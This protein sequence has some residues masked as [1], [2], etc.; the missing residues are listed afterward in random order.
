M[1]EICFYNLDMFFFIQALLYSFSIIFCYQIFNKEKDPSFLFSIFAMVVL[2]INIFYAG[3]GRLAD[4][5][6]DFSVRL[7]FFI[8]ILIDAFFIAFKGK[9]KYF[10]RSVVLVLLAGSD[11]TYDWLYREIFAALMCFPLFLIYFNDLKK[12]KSSGEI[13]NLSK[14]F[15]F[16]AL[17]LIFSFIVIYKI[18]QKDFKRFY[19]DTQKNLF[20]IK[21]RIEREIDNSHTLLRLFPGKKI[22]D[23]LKDPIENNDDKYHIYERFDKLIS[24]NQG[25][26]VYIMDR[27]GTVLL[28]SNHNEKDSFEDKNFN[29]RPYF[30]EALHGQDSSYIA[31]GKVSGKRGLYISSPITDSNNKVVGVIV[32]KRPMEIIDDMLEYNV[33]IISEYGLIFSSGNKD[34]LLRFITPKDIEVIN[35]LRDSQQFYLSDIPTPILSKPLEE[36]KIV[37]DESQSIWENLLPVSFKLSV[38][39]F[40]IIKLQEFDGLHERRILIDMFLF[41]C[42]FFLFTIIAHYQNIKVIMMRLRNSERNLAQTLDLMAVLVF[43]VDES[44]NLLYY[45]KAFNDFFGLVDEVSNLKD[46]V[47]K[48]SIPDI[49]YIFA[50]MKRSPISD[51]EFN[52]KD[53]KGDNKF[54]LISSTS[55]IR[56]SALNY[57]VVLYDITGKKE[58]MKELET[59]DNKYSYTL[60]SLPLPLVEIGDDK[61]IYL[62]NESFVDEFFFERDIPCLVEDVFSENSLENI[63]NALEKVFK[64]ERVDNIEISRRKG[65]REKYFLGSAIPVY[66]KGHLTKGRFIFNNITSLI[67]YENEIRDLFIAVD[68]SLVGISIYTKDLIIIYCN[69]M[70]EE[71]TGYKKSEIIGNTSD[72]IGMNFIIR[73]KGWEGEITLNDKQGKEKI[74]Y[75]KISPVYS[76]NKNITGYVSVIIDV[77][78]RKELEK[79]LLKAKKKAE[80]LSETRKLLMM[81][82][83]HEIN[84]PL[85]KI[86]NIAQ[87]SID[88]CVDKNTSEDLKNI[89]S[90]SKLLNQIIRNILI[91]SEIEMNGYNMNMKETDVISTIEDTVSNHQ[92]Y[93]KEK[94]VKINFEKKDN[95][96]EDVILID[97]NVLELVSGNLISNA[98]K[99]SKDGNVDINISLDKERKNILILTV[100][101]NGVGIEKNKQTL[102]FEPFFQ[103][104]DSLRRQYQ[105]LGIGLSI[106]KKVLISIGGD[107]FLESNKGTGS[108]FRARIPYKISANKKTTKVE[109]DKTESKL[110]NIGK[111]NVLVVDDARENRF[112][113]KTYLSKLGIKPDEASGGEEALLLI[114]DKDY[115]IILLDIQMPGIDGYQ[116]LDEAR[117]LEEGRSKKAFIIALT[118]HSLPEDVEKSKAAGFDEHISKPIR[119]KEFLINI[120]EVIERMI[121]G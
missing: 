118:A 15:I 42:F 49:I 10:L 29:F 33:F 39:G 60:E 83:S 109:T 114:K 40:N 95:R 24:L 116:V 69:P 86:I 27:N 22:I 102:I 11:L 4:F 103:E 53:Q 73:E 85:N 19:S 70:F 47:H 119:K 68:T 18:G 87:I 1:Y 115:D 16:F 65:K 12:I 113:V 111:I 25:S 76:N 7:F 62:V 64:G 78:D 93:A 74:M 8:I 106:V 28:S 88:Q 6:Y 20:E 80:R 21:G 2:I 14:I 94:G 71:I 79:D 121:K 54:V 52:F 92:E 98:I 45:N 5:N 96:I 57:R 37:I 82:M 34:D 77:S 101:D 58:L 72:K 61:N 43:E 110:K 9:E 84:T 105:G 36:G 38:K 50:K 81:K 17:L 59:T 91:L 32:L 97:K 66:E 90:E 26:I 51:F 30:L 100:K 41:F 63:N 35:K 67:R 117:Q 75:Q 56:N 99:F 23:I 108:I 46:V 55:F 44:L 104:E 3:I 107:I 48:D 112:I 120:K 13:K 31:V 89:I